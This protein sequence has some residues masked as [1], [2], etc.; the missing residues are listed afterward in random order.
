MIGIS[1]EDCM[2]LMPPGEAR[3]LILRRNDGPVVYLTF[4]EAS[5]LRPEIGPPR[6]L[7]G[8]IAIALR[9]CG[10]EAAVKRHWGGCGCARRQAWL[11][12]HFP[13]DRKS[14]V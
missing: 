10:I 11:D 9:Y 3:E 1:R 12:T 8:F 4:E 14:V 2:R 13:L 6:G 7:G 5:L